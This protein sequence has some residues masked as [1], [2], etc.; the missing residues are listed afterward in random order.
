MRTKSNTNVKYITLTAVCAA[1]IAV[2]TA[3]I[4]FP[5]PMQN[6]IHFGDGLI[7]LTVCILPRPYAMIAASI[8]GGLADLMVA[9]MWIIPTMIIK[10]LIT[11]PFANKGNKILNKRNLIAPIFAYIISEVGYFLA[12][13]YFYG[14]PEGALFVAIFG[15][16][17]GFIQ[18]FG[19]A[20]VF[21]FV[22]IALDKIGFKA[23]F[24]SKL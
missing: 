17:G 24:M 20:V 4:H 10:P 8:G 11:L 12:N 5:A 1:L 23:K 9:P 14:T 16:I 6:Y 19:S 21:F 13:A 7:Y 22:A 3:F 15:S 18:S 2:L